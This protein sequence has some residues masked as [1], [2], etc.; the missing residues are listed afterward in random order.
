MQ[1]NLY[2]VGVKWSMHCL[3]QYRITGKLYA[4]TASFNN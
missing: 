4:R 1:H 2:R 3:W